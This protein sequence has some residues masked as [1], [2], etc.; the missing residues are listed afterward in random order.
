MADWRCGCRG[1]AL[2]DDGDVL[3]NADAVFDAVLAGQFPAGRQA[4]ALGILAGDDLLAKRLGKLVAF[5]ADKPVHGGTL[6]TI[7]LLQPVGLSSEEWAGWETVGISEV[8]P[9]IVGDGTV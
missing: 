6:R 2:G 5:E 7:L 1:K 8:Q 3:R 9:F 4:A